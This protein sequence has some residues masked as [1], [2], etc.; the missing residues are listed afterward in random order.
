MSERTI[1]DEMISAARDACIEEI[2]TCPFEDS[3][4]RAILSAA[5]STQQAAQPAASQPG[6]EPQS[7]EVNQGLPRIHVPAA[8]AK[9]V[10]E[11]A[12]RVAAPFFNQS[13]SQQEQTNDRR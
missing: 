7:G 13:A 10:Q 4:L 5:L 1:T 9:A 3:H 11:R 12:K 8:S 2:F 6:T